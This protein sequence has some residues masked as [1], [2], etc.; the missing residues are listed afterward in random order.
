VIQVGSL[1][2]LVRSKELPGR[3][4]DLQHLAVLYEERPELSLPEIGQ[5]PDRGLDRGL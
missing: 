2:D 4:K 5:K 1:I 3:E